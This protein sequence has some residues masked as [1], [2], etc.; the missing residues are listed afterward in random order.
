[1]ESNNFVME[2]DDYLMTGREVAEK[3]FIH[4]K[5]VYEVEKRAIEKLRKIMAQK[6]LQAKDIL[7]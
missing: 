4:E 1:M 6:G 5:T 7:I 3:L 2:H